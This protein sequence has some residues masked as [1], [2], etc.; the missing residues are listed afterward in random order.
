MLRTTSDQ[1]KYSCTPSP[2]RGRQ[3]FVAAELHRAVSG[4]TVTMSDRE[5][6]RW[7]PPT[8]GRTHATADLAVGYIRANH[9]EVV[10]VLVRMA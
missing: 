10:T 2:V 3:K 4:F 5:G 8:G 9:P 1:P 7:N 6:R